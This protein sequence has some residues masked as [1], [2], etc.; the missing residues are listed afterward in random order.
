MR[1]HIPALA[2]LSL[3]IAIAVAAPAP[4]QEGPGKAPTAAQQKA[5]DAARSQLDAAARRYVELPANT[6]SNAAP[7]KSGNACCANR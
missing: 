1:H 5:L 2:A 6:A 4:A 3:A 7:W